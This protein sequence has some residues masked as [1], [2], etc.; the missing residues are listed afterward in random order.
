[1]HFTKGLLT[2]P[3]DMVPFTSGAHANVNVKQVEQAIRRYDYR[4]PWCF[5]AP[6]LAATLQRQM[7]IPD[8]V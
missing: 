4:S 6:L 7:R 2:L 5:V 3:V 1:M 8:N